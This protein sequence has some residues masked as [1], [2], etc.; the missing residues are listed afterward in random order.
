[1]VIECRE[2]TGVIFI[3]LIVLNVNN[4][5]RM[6]YESKVRKLLMFN[7]IIFNAMNELLEKLISLF[8]TYVK[9]SLNRLDSN[10]AILCHC[11]EIHNHQQFSCFLKISLTWRLYTF[12][13]SFINFFVWQNWIEFSFKFWIFIKCCFS[14][15]D[16]NFWY[17]WVKYEFLSNN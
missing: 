3:S 1:M 8:P 9:M 2:N 5:I 15:K 17:L 13:I 11:I 6:P 12:S 4:A 14:F 10:L 7:L 16:W